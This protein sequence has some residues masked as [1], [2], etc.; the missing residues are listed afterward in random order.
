[1]LALAAPTSASALP[2]LP[3][4]L[5]PPPPDI[6]MRWVHRA[7]AARTLASATFAKGRAVVGLAAHVSAA[8]LARQRGLRL[9]RALPGLRAVELAGPPS[10]LAALASGS[11]VR[12][13]EPVEP[14]TLAHTRDDPLTYEDDPTTGVPWEWSF[15]ALGVDQALNLSKGDPSIVVGVLD[16][17]ISSVPDLR[18]KIAGAL[19]DPATTTSAAD[20]SGH[21]TLISSI[22][23]ARNDDGFGLAGFC[24]ACRVLVWKTYPLNTVE[25]ANGIRKLTDAHVRLLNISLVSQQSDVVTDAIDY[26]LAAGVLVVAASG[27]DGDASVSFPASLAQQGNGLLAVGASNAAG[28]RASFSNYGPQLSLLA[29]G[30]FRGSCANGIIGAIP[31]IAISFDTGIGCDATLLDVHGSR[32]AYANGTSFAAPQVAGI[33]ALVWAASPTLT[34]L[35]VADVLEQTARRASGSGWTPETGWGIADA[36]AA[37]EKVTGRS[38]A[39]TLRLSGL[40]VAGWRAG[41]VVRA[42]VGA[43]WGDGSEVDVGATPACAIRVR[44]RAVATTASLVSGVVGCTFTL[45]PESSG[46]TVRGTVSLRAPTAHTVA[47]AL[48]FRARG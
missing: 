12:Y 24:G 30:T 4:I 44:G 48:S 25:L 3:S 21:G 40:H 47:A 6:A 42:T 15:H 43:V 33:A 32:Y 31:S 5:P 41:G 45:P 28:K 20:V 2:P 23:A 38:S 22:I 8:S 14:V 17:G 29:P 46:A 19:W 13:A 36:N 11:N 10:A 37:V 34:N 35:Q 9:V 26:A 16:S 39:D 18:G 1:M 27:N 7:P